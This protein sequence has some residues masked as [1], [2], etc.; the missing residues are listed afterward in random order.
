MESKT[1]AYGVAWLE[2]R[3]GEDGAENST[4]TRANPL[5]LTQSDICHDESLLKACVSGQEKP[6]F[7]Y[8][9]SAAAD[10]N[11]GDP[12]TIEPRREKEITGTADLDALAHMNLLA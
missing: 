10:A 8:R 7:C 1:T 3:G 11:I 4:E 2:G 5:A 6:A 9:N 12:R